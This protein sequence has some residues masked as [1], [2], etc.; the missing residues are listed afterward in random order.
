MY[1][2]KCMQIFSFL[3]WVEG[4][5]HLMHHHRFSIRFVCANVSGSTKWYVWFTVKCWKSPIVGMSETKQKNTIKQANN[6]K[7]QKKY[8]NAHSIS[9]KFTLKTKQ[10]IYEKKITIK[11]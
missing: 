7:Y 10:H 6:K 1:S 8:I 4:N 9:R 5:L 11:I 2:N 3:V